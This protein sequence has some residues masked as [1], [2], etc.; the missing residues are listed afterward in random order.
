[1]SIAK[2]SNMLSKHFAETAV[3]AGIL[4]YRTVFSMIKD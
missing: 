3:H 2:V 4:S 1:M